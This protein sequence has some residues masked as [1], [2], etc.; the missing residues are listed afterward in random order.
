QPFCLLP[1]SPL[2]LRQRARLHSL[3][4]CELRGGQAAVLPSLDDLDP[5]TSGTGR[6]P[7]AFFRH[8][9]ALAG[10]PPTVNDVLGGTG[11][12]ACASTSTCLCL[13]V[14]A[15]PRG[16]HSTAA[17]GN[18]ENSASASRRAPRAAYS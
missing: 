10:V 15:G 17:G 9:Q 14:D 5:L 7:L 11:T 2:P 16:D 18:F 6:C 8:R 1:K 3:L 12:R 4:V 13:G